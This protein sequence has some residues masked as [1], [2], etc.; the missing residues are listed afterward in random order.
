M[1]TSCSLL[2]AIIVLPLLSACATPSQILADSKVRQLCEKDGGITV[3][4]T[5][6]LP[7][8]RYDQYIRDIKSKN[9]IRPTDEYYLDGESITLKQGYTR[10]I[11]NKYQIIR[12][13]DGKVMG[14][15]VRYSRSGG[16]IPGP[17]H[18][19]S[20]GCPSLPSTLE[21]SIFIKG[22]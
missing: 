18:G 7:A 8:D 17:W 20:Y 6:K 21:S 2:L 14:E 11:R 9:Y 16:D 5:V 4:E 19:T 13:R 1:K 12:V 10:I 15:S 3:Y 22:E